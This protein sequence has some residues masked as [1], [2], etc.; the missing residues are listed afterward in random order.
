[1]MKKGLLTIFASLF[2]AHSALIHATEFVKHSE[3]VGTNESVTGNQQKIQKFSAKEK[4]C[5]RWENVCVKHSHRAPMRDGCYR[6]L[7]PSHYGVHLYPRMQTH[8]T[9][10]YETAQYLRTMGYRCY[11]PYD[12][13]PCDRT[14]GTQNC[15]MKCVAYRDESQPVY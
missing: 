11:V 3:N 8:D 6:C 13:S 14:A 7:K 9:C 4:N 12:T 15:H 10:N 1:M 5:I 2:I